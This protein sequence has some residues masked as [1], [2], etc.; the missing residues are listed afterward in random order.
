[1]SCSPILS[2][3]PRQVQRRKQQAWQ[4]FSQAYRA[5]LKR[6]FLF[7]IDKYRQSIAS[8]P[9]AEAHTFLGWTYSHVGNLDAAIEQCKL[10]ITL[11]KEFGN[12][13]NDIGA[14]LI[15]QGNPQEAI[16]YLQRALTVKRYKVPHYAHYNL[17]RAYERL[18][19]VLLAFKHYQQALAIDP[20]YF[21]A[22]QAIRSLRQSVGNAQ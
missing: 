17:A 3:Q 9:T 18:G 4:Y 5:Q 21:M 14:Y 15:A 8:Y 13:Y 10:A 7:A 16:P 11:D 2:L 20:S 19:N 22:Q 12:P 6:N 1:M